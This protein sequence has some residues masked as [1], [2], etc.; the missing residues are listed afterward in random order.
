MINFGLKSKAP[1]SLMVAMSPRL[2]LNP[3]HLLC[4]DHV[5]G[6]NVLLITQ[7]RKMLVIIVTGMN[8][9]FNP[10]HNR[11]VPMRP[12]HC[13]GVKRARYGGDWGSVPNATSSTHS[14]PMGERIHC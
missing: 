7:T 14:L 13:M 5:S 10:V 11:F 2:P 3:P 6:R 9:G 1:K 12:M 8:S 4:L